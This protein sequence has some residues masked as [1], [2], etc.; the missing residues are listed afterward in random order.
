MSVDSLSKKVAYGALADFYAALLTEKQRTLLSMYCNEDLSLSE[1]AGRESISR[2][3]V[4]EH[5]NRAYLRLDTLEEELRMFARFN[6]LKDAV[7][8]CLHQLDQ[9]EATQGTAHH[10]RMAQQILHQHMDEEG[11]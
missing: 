8:Q 3:A 10:L 5:L 6:D 11:E 7:S 4:S 9:V 1:I 2:Q